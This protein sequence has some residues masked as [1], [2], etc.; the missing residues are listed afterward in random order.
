MPITPSSWRASTVAYRAL[1]FA[2][3]MAWAIASLSRIVLRQRGV[4]LPTRTIG[5]ALTMLS[6]VALGAGLATYFRGGKV[7]ELGSRR[8]TVIV[9]WV[10][11]HAAGLL[12]WFGYVASG[13]TMC[14]IAGVAMLALMHLF[15]PNRLRQTSGRE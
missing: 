9:T 3:T 1:V 10:C 12:A 5:P 4:L 13:D 2:Q 6:M 7:S 8:M 14:F 15:S 11:L